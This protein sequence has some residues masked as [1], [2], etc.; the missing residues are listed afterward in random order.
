MSS[1][2]ID[3]VSTLAVSFATSAQTVV[4]SAFLA[5]LVGAKPHRLLLTTA[6]AGYPV[7]SSSVSCQVSSA[8]HYDVV[9]GF[10]W[11]ANLRDSLLALG[12]RLDS[13]FDAWRIFSGAN[14]SPVGGSPLHSNS[15]P[16]TSVRNNSQTWSPPRGSCMP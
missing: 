13:S 15:P 11:A 9:L 2:L 14:N 1:I 10:D 16:S 12:Y 8:I 7:C 6:L 3:G 4:S 5:K